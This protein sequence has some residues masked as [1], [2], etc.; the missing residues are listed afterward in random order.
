MTW[1]PSCEPIESNNEIRRNLW[2]EVSYGR[3]RWA[4]Y[5]LLTCVGENSAGYYA[6]GTVAAKILFDL[7]KQTMIRCADSDCPRHRF[8]RLENLV[9]L[10]AIF[11]S[12]GQALGENE[13]AVLTPRPSWTTSRVIGS[14]EP[15]PPYT[16]DPVF[17]QIAW[18][19]PV[20][21]I[22][23]PG[24]EWLI[25]IE[26]P[27]QL[28]DPAEPSSQAGGKKPP[29]RFAPARARRVLDRAGDERSAPFLELKDRAI[30]C[31]AFHPHYR[32]NGQIF[33]CS[34]THPEGGTGINTL[35]RFVVSRR[36]NDDHDNKPA[37]DPA[38]EE[39][40]LEWPSEGHDGGAAVFGHDGMLFVSTGDGSPDSD[41]NLTAQDPN[42]LLGKIL[43]IDVDRP[44]AEMKYA[45]PPDNPFL[46]L[47]GARGE[48]WSLGHRNPWRM[49]VDARTGHLW[50]GNNGQDLWEFA[51]LIKPGD[52]V[53]W[54]V[55]EG[56]HP[57]YLNRQRGPGNLAQ[58][59]VEH[60]HGAF[61]SLTGGVVYYGQKHPA[62][63]GAYIYG[64]Y[65]T[66]AIRSV[67]HDGTKVLWNRE[68][69]RTTLNIVGFAISH[70]DE[71]L[72]VDYT[73]GIYRL[74][75]SRPDDSYRRFPHRLSETGLFAS[76]RD[77]R[78][79]PGVVHYV[80]SVPGW[81]DGAT[82]ERL[83]ALPG[84]NHIQR[85]GAG[86]WKIPDGTVL[87]QTLSLPSHPGDTAHTR[88][89]ETRLL[90][91]QKGAWAAYSYVWNDTQD[92]ATLAPSGGIDVHLP[93]GVA[94]SRGEN[95]APQTWR[96]PSRTECMSCHSRQANF[97]LGFTEL[98]TDRSQKYNEGEMN[99]LHALAEQKVIDQIAPPLSPDRQRLVNPYDT[100]Q[101]LEARVRSYLHANC[102]AC[103]I[104]T[105]GGNSRI[106]LN[107]EQKRED[108]QL[109]DVFPQHDSFGLSAALLV[110]PGEPQR[111]VLYH[112]VSRRGPGQMP[113]RGTA[114]V[115]QQAVQLIRDWIEKLPPQRK[116][117]KDW[118]MDDLAPSLNQLEHG[119]SYETGA[120]VFKEL[121]CIQ[122][123]R[124]AG[125]GGG[126]GP[127]LTGVAKKQ[128]PHELL[129]SILE[130]SKK[131]APEFAATIVITVDGKSHEGR[132]AQED[133][134]KLVLHTS[135]SL[136][137]PVTILKS[138]I[139]ERKL[140]T[141]S[142]MPA[143]LLNTLEKSE[144]LDL[145]AY[146]VADANPK[147]PAFAR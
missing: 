7:T 97:V 42:S 24:S 62:L 131:I 93:A 87:V 92:D 114:V 132:I 52:N 43:R 84:D 3:N 101:D 16:V 95:A 58:P 33:V 130:P 146:V 145:L 22:R 74:V 104:E 86:N 9:A 29:P 75:D 48:I 12:A 45:I 73:S 8:M 2:I 10:V 100:T 136:V 127:E 147:H 133:N 21:A 65:A 5:D 66:G 28:A 98:Q 91:K 18:K 15:P 82:A 25:I 89:I 41:N 121:G 40:I 138:E 61:R 17:T 69:A 34:R 46:K 85:K 4:A 72:V 54:S 63:E 6:A 68:V 126:A 134:Q 135:G 129:E 140:S 112:R 59:A 49:T 106:R 143:R 20:F 123:H 137:A 128:T 76:T 56:S 11:Q 115:D 27:Q 80:V 102:S 118:A 35:S 30:Y 125:N 119:R 38:G 81:T 26:W 55:Y 79:T 31:L 83:V 110:A 13:K 122:C 39:R 57:F 60:D 51:H 90:T 120:R 103:H 70:R 47:K 37:S 107:I 142:T 113:P 19:N 77:H 88:R 94:P 109:V 124:F 50:V 53:G 141:I 105:G 64:D 139:E 23:E 14:P 116:F 32:D 78:P 108:M 96:V 1:K 36:G 99:Q 44:A 144:I 71:L 117:V 111:S 67:R